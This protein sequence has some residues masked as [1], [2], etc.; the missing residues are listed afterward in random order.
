MLVAPDA[1]RIKNLRFN[2][3]PVT[4]EQIFLVATNNYRASGG[5]NFP[6][7]GPDVIVID[8][9]DENRQVLANYIAGQDSVDPQ[10]DGNWSFAP[11]ASDVIVEFETSPDAAALAEAFPR[12]VPTD[13]INPAGY[14]VY[15]YDFSP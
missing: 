13:A 15:H 6:G 11:I 5:G 4:D 9:P 1:E 8:A 12:L 10:A 2:G 3:E 14:Q 7:L